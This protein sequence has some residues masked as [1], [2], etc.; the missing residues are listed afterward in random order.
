MPT[1][2]RHVLPETTP[3]RQKQL[4]LEALVDQLERLAAE[5]PVLLA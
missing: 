5:Q 3:Q 1:A 2:G 4:T